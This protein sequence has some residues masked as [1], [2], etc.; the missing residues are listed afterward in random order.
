MSCNQCDGERI[1]YKK[2][3]YTE[4]LRLVELFVPFDLRTPAEQ[5][6]YTDNL[7]TMSIY[8]NNYK[9]SAG[10]ATD[11]ASIVG[12]VTNDTVKLLLNV[13]DDLEIQF[14]YL[15]YSLTELSPV[16]RTLVELA[17]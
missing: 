14:K 16:R 6:R 7:F 17:K 5:Q 3:N 15:K 2:A 13:T 11:L 8:L 4:Y 1:Y 10:L 9:S 12:G